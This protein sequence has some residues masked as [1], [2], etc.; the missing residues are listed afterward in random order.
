MR[1]REEAVGAAEEYPDGMTEIMEG[2]ER[3]C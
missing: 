3:G 2:D 1:H